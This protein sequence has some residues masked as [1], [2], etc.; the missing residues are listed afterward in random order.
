MPRSTDLS[1][2][3][4]VQTSP[5]KVLVLQYSRR[6]K[7]SSVILAFDSFEAILRST[8]VQREIVGRTRPLSFNGVEI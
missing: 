6:G 3:D 4:K 1:G 5:N 7:H 8:Y 2:T